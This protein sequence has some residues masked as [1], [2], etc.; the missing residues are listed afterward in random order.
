MIPS[1]YR[2]HILFWA[3][4]FLLIQGCSTT[5]AQKP[6]SRELPPALFPALCAFFIENEDFDPSTVTTV[7]D[8]TRPIYE[9]FALR[10]LHGTGPLTPAESKEDSTR[11]EALRSR[12][13]AS[14]V[15]LPKDSGSCQWRLSTPTIAARSDTNTLLLQLSNVV[16]DPF[17]QTGDFRHGVF[18]RLALQG[19]PGSWFWI[20]L[21]KT[22]NA[23]EIGAISRLDISDG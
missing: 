16:E 12:F 19:N 13:S 8:E 4:S 21:Q 9:T 10:V 15:E 2:S 18:A 14:Q 7:V 20:P 22:G 23:W 1:P 11:D 17:A 6:A 3:T 5:L